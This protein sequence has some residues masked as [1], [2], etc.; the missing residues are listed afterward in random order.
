MASPRNPGVD[1]I[2]EVI[3]SALLCLDLVYP[4]SSFPGAGGETMML[5]IANWRYTVLKQLLLCLGAHAQ[6][7]YTVIGLVSLCVCVCACV[8]VP[9]L[10]VLTVKFKRL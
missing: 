2:V 10:T 4:S 8:S 7:R 5:L 9:A 3:S 1:L 6:A